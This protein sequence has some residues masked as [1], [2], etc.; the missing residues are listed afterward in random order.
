MHL[1]PEIKQQMT[2]DKFVYDSMTAA[3]DPF[4]QI[5]N[6]QTAYA[7]AVMAEHS[8]QRVKDIV[9]TETAGHT[10]MATAQPVQVNASAAEKT[11]QYHREKAFWGC[12]ATDHNFSRKGG[13]IVCLKVHLPEVKANADKHFEQFKAMRMRAAESKKKKT[14]KLVATIF[15]GWKDKDIRTF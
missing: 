8:L 14:H 11:L 3:R 2:A 1:I 10:F 13:H 7:A 12:G 9:K 6:L 4:T 15:K 5:T